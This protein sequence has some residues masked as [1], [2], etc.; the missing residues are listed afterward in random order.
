MAGPN[1]PKTGP[2][3]TERLLLRGANADLKELSSTI[4]VDRERD[5]VRR[6]TADERSQLQSQINDW[7]YEHEKDDESKAVLRLLDELKLDIEQPDTS[8]QVTGG[9]LGTLNY[10]AN[11]TVEGVVGYPVTKATEGYADLARYARDET[12]RLANAGSL[13]EKIG[14]GGKNILFFGGIAWGTSVVFSKISEWIDSAW[15]PKSWTNS[16][17]HAGK[18]VLG[19]TGIGALAN[20]LLRKG[21]GPDAKITAP[22]PRASASN[23][24][25]PLPRVYGELSNIPEGKNLLEDLAINERGKTEGRVEF[26]VDGS[27]VTVLPPV[28]DGNEFA[29]HFRLDGVEYALSPTPGTPDDPLSKA[30]DDVVRSLMSAPNGAPNRDAREALAN[31]SR[32]AAI[33]RRDDVI[34]ARMK[35]GVSVDLQ[36]SDLQ[37]LVKGLKQSPDKTAFV[38]VPLVVQPGNIAI[39]RRFALSKTGRIEKRPTPAPAP[40]AAPPPPVD[41]LKITPT[42]PASPAPAPAEPAAPDPAPAATS[43]QS[44]TAATSVTTSAPTPGPAAAPEIPAGY[45][46]ITPRFNVV[47]DGKSVRFLQG[48]EKIVL[49]YNGRRFSLQDPEK[50]G[51]MGSNATT[52]YLLA[53]SGDSATQKLS[54]GGVIRYDGKEYKRIIESLDA[55]TGTVV[56]VPN[57]TFEERDDESKF[58]RKQQTFTFDRV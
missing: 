36:I 51:L 30:M 6:L 48:P 43:A 26:T 2:I 39:S 15:E 46:D 42:P 19:V 17:S 16:L 37:Q 9:G 8:Y 54:V 33:E 58:V 53:T 32:K 1:I 27:T 38:D 4:N 10:G 21:K 55:S 57:V 28:N 34:R 23:D 29:A 5:H 56:A 45:E 44:P 47:I 25:T 3:V 18:W 22:P 41:P 50:S 7:K 11:K 24:R 20:L 52:F 12:A 14:I 35:G 49:S 13:Q 40:A 31:A